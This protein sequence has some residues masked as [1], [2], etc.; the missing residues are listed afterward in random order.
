[1]I[2]L[3]SPYAFLSKYLGAILLSFFCYY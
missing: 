2:K 1:M 3:Y